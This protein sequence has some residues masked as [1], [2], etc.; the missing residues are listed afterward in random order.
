VNVTIQGSQ[1]SSTAG[2]IT[3]TA[4]A[5]GATPATVSFTVVSVTITMNAKPGAQPAADD[6]AGSSYLPGAPTG[7]GAGIVTLPTKNNPPKC[8]VG[9]EFTGV[10]TP[11]NYTG[12]VTLRRNFVNT[13][14]PGELYQNQT[15]YFTAYFT[16]T[17]GHGPGQDD[18]SDPPL[19]DNDPQSAN[20]NGHVYD[21][22]APGIGLPQTMD[23][24][25]DIF[26]Y[27]AN[28]L[29]YAVL[30]DRTSTLQVGSSFPW[31]ARASC[32]MNQQSGEPQ[33]SQDVANDN[34]V[35]TGT[36]PITWNL[37]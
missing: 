2:N 10:V 21:I 3:L 35:G 32:A 14:P 22:D 16:P 13:N 17:E 34:Q 11:S 30:G 5:Q 31:W 33:L 12:L 20:S 25:N 37:K 24:P 27:R 23:N 19:I 4:T 36:T 15:Q 26:R 6:G 9:V 18:T 7:L 8:A 29:E 28:F 1:V